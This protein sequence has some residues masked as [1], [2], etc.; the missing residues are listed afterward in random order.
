MAGTLTTRE[1]RVRRNWLEPLASLRDEFGDLASHFLG[2][3][4][5]A[6]PRGM[7]VPSL[8]L[9]ESDGAIEIRMDLPGIKAEEIDVQLTDNT[10]TVSGQRKEEKEVKGKTYHRVERHQGSFSRT[11]VLP[12]LVN[13]AKVDAQ[14]KDGVLTI[15]IPKTDEAKARKIKVHA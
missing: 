11:D 8:D 13:E 2:D 15:K 4:A 14:Y 6:W 5:E 3:V 1:P 7:M 9:S 10:L 12:C